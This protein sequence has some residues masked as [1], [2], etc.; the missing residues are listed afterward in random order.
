MIY[1]I[2]WFHSCLAL[3][4]LAGCADSPPPESAP[5]N[6][7]AE[8][9]GPPPDIIAPDSDWETVA[10]PYLYSD[11]PTTDKDGNLYFAV[12]PQNKLYRLTPSGEVSIFDED[13]AQSMGL[14]IGADGRLFACRNNDAQ[15]VAYDMLGGR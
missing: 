7:R 9:P 13:T 1:R 10:G 4:L 15:M 14:R 2:C 5:K 6:A 12:T 8:L 11:G 3:A